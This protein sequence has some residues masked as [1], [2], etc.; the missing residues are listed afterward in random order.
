MLQAEHDPAAPVAAHD[1]HAGAGGARVGREGR[2]HVH[3]QRAGQQP[4]VGHRGGAV[5]QEALAGGAR[6]DGRLAR[7]H[8]AA[9]DLLHEGVREQPL[10]RGAR[11]GVH[12]DEDGL[13]EHVAR[14]G[15]GVGVRHHAAHVLVADVR[16]HVEHVGA[17]EVGEEA[18]AGLA[19][20][21]GG[22]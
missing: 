11:G 13:V 10:G 9:E 19:G 22:D 15:G 3:V 1:G 14:A 21:G 17:A 20:V 6:E 2:V 7:G 18:G 5:E 12:G 8:G 4:A 16:D